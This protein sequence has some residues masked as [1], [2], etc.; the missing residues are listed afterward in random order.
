MKWD[1]IKDRNSKDLRSRRDKKEI[2]RILRR[3]VYKK[4]S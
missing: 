3:T 1:R 2:E 4:R